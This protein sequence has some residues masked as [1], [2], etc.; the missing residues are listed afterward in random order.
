MTCCRRC[1]IS[2]HFRVYSS[3]CA[4]LLS[5]ETFQRK[6]VYTDSSCFL[7]LS[8]VLL[9][10]TSVSTINLSTY[11]LNLW[12]H[13]D[14][15]EDVREITVKLNDFIQVGKDVFDVFWGENTVSVQ[16]LIE[17]TVQHLQ[18]PQMGSL[19]VEQLWGMIQR[20]GKFICI[21]DSNHKA[22]H[23]TYTVIRRGYKSNR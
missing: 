19:S 15:C 13:C 22:L 4:N 1:T 14:F 6:N 20:Q 16:P 23:K 12:W 8:S 18:H 9:P 7:S 21:A 5:L 3:S 10:L 17:N 11:T 2:L